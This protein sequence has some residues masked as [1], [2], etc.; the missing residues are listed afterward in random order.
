MHSDIMTLRGFII[1]KKEKINKKQ[2][3]NNKRSKEIK[4]RIFFGN[5]SE[6]KHLCRHEMNYYFFCKSN[7]IAINLIVG[8][9]NVIELSKNT[10]L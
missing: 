6:K 2:N 8:S 7:I 10:S 9:G 4:V 5:N 3:K 1:S